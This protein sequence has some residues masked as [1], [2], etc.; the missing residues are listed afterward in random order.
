MRCLAQLVQLAQLPL[1][2][3]RVRLEPSGMFW[4]C[5]TVRKRNSYRKMT[6]QRLYSSAI[7]A[8]FLVTYRINRHYS[9]RLQG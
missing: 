3:Q 5:S 9:S 7:S 8:Q 6:G 2:L 4:S 1:E